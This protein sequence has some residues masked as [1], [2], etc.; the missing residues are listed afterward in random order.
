MTRTTIL[1]LCVVALSA[2]PGLADDELEV[3]WED[4]YDLPIMN[5][6]WAS[7]GPYYT[8]DDFTLDTRSLLK[9][10]EY[11]AIY[12]YPDDDDHPQQFT[13]SIRYDHYG[14][15]GGW[16]KVFRP[17]LRN[18]EET[19]TGD[20]YLGYTVWHYRV[21]LGSGFRLDGGTPWWLEIYS[22]AENFKWGARSQGNL[23][24]QWN[25]WDKS[26]FFRILGTPDDT[27]VEAASWG[28]IKAGFSD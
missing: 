14:M 10:I 22:D 8:Q 17:P 9:V 3:L 24:H 13:F 5:S 16:K 21:D 7:W 27:R 20:V 2:V 25:Q 15:P 4:P 6:V 26:A 11:W 19:D 18:I 1:L 23:H 28:E 12:Y